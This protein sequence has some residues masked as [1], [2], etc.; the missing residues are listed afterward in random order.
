MLPWVA[1]FGSPL[2]VTVRSH[3]V[4]TAVT[5]VVVLVFTEFVAETDEVAVIVP[6]AMVGATFTTTTMSAAVPEAMLGSVQLTFPVAPT[7]G[8]VHVQPT[9][10]DTD[11]NVV[12]SGV[13]SVKL[14]AVAATGPLFVTVWV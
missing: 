8:V 6:A 1:G 10:A 4:A 2:L 9:G 5:V 3:T 13:A 7:A 12:L 11:W 14:T